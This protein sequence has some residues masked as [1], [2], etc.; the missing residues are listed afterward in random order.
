MGELKNGKNVIYLSF[1]IKNPFK[2][3]IYIT[4]FNFEG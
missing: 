1:L 2:N 4:N 3:M